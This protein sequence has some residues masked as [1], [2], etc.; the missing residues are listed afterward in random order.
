MAKLEGEILVN[1]ILKNSFYCP[2]LLLG[3]YDSIFKSMYKG[4]IFKASTLEDVRDIVDRFYGIDDLDGRYFVLDGVGFLNSTGQN[5]LLKFVEECKFPLVLLSYYDTVS[6]II[7]SRM[8]FVYKKS[9]TE[10][11]GLDFVRVK[12]VLMM[13]ED[14]KRTDS[15]FSEI[16][17]VKLFAEYCPPA[18]ALKYSVPWFDY[19]ASRML[20]LIS[21]L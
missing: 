20:K 19:S 10:V 6:P 3:K 4:R 12:D 9:V 8:K 17:E 7:M 16:D 21:K 5:A 13:I 18:F 1:E 11:K 15:D 14:K 2:C